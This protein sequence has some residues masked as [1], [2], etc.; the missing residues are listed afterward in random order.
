M[1]LPR[2]LP[3]VRPRV[4]SRPTGKKPKSLGALRWP[5]AGAVGGPTR[6]FIGWPTG[7]LVMSQRRDRV[8]PAESAACL[9]F[10]VPPI[11]TPTV[12]VDCVDDAPGAG[13]PPLNFW[14][15]ISMK[16]SSGGFN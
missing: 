11:A 6:L 9:S 14:Y 8:G 1:K 10:F 15:K 7:P 4:R 16:I 13:L 5:R 12:E 2:G 3:P